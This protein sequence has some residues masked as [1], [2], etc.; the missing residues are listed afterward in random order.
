MC[1]LILLLIV[2]NVINTIHIFCEFTDESPLFRLRTSKT[3]PL[4]IKILIYPLCFVSNVFPLSIIIIVQLLAIFC[5]A[6]SYIWLYLLNCDCVVDR[7][8]KDWVNESILPKEIF[9]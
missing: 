2:V 4:F 3:I 6:S 1:I 7:T 9:L 5:S 8:F